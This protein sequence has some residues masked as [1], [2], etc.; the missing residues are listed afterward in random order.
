MTFSEWFYGGKRE[1]E[2]ATEPASASGPLQASIDSLERALNL[3]HAEIAELC[4]QTRTD[5]LQREVGSL[6]GARRVAVEQFLR[7]W[8]PEIQ[9]M[10]KEFAELQKQHG[11]LLAEKAAAATVTTSA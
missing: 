5:A 3:K 10:R 2:P 9:R 4:E 7:D 11:S 1:S 8:L 6:R